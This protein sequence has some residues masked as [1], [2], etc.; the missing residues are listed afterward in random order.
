MGIFDRWLRAAALVA[1]A[2]GG[3]VEPL[4]EAG[5]ECPCTGEFVCCETTNTCLLTR[6]ECPSMP[7]GPDGSTP[8][9]AGSG[10]DVP[11]RA[12]AEAGASIPPDVSTVD[13]ANPPDAPTDEA[14]VD[15]FDGG[16]DGDAAPPDVSA[17]DVVEAGDAAPDV[18][19]G[20]SVDVLAERDAQ[21]PDPTACWSEPRKSN[22][23]VL[24]YNPYLVSYGVTLFNQ[25]AS[26]NNDPQFISVRLAEQVRIASHGLVNYDIVEFRE[27]SA[28][29][30]Q[31]PDAPPLDEM[32]FFHGPPSGNYTNYAN[33]NADYADIFASQDLCNYVN[34]HD[35]SEIWLWG[36]HG[37][38][39]TFGFDIYSYKFA[40]DRVPPGADMALYNERKRNI[41]D[42]GRSLWVMGFDYALLYD[43]RV[44]S[45]RSEEILRAS[46]NGLV[47]EGGTEDPFTK[48]SHFAR[49]LTNDIE[50]G[51]PAYPPNGG[52]GVDGDGAWDYANH[53]IVQSAADD[54]Y[55]YPAL[56]G[57]TKPTD[58]SAWS[59][60][61]EGYQAW[62]ASHF[63][64]FA[65]GAPDHG[66]NNWWKYIAD[67]DGRLA[68]CS[69]D[70]CLPEYPKGHAC[71]GDDQC[72]TR[73]CSCQASYM[74]C[75]DAPGPACPNI[76]WE[77]CVV[78]GDCRSGV[79]GC[80]GGQPPK[81]CLPDTSYSRVC[82]TP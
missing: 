82:G 37:D 62:Y 53:S 50:V 52:V 7:E 26:W 43:P 67:P 2:L 15:A 46:L 32:S 73:H 54:W 66:C 49:D 47:P 31:L 8:P 27:L 72:A 6:S 69:G 78:D 3:C 11:A 36:A 21:P 45:M 77:A 29:P 38:F 42:C 68:S 56:T 39:L 13:T 55:T 24:I 33:G 30:K 64:H 40:G 9:D 58:C 5:R 71:T 61:T 80:L 22:V 25:V 59:C 18:T 74:V 10:G 76:N 41:P 70:S 57:A 65:G 17:P 44:Y 34:E 35:V 19:D 79:C 75:S 23:L 4:S 60:T 81:V 63:P 14:M 1:V 20:S 12:D 28:W 48:F 51:T 16:L